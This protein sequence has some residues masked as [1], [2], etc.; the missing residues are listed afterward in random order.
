[1]TSRRGVEVIARLLRRAG[2]WHRPASLAHFE[3]AHGL[4]VLEGGGKLESLVEI[5]SRPKA[6][7]LR[8]PGARWRWFAPRTKAF[9]HRLVKRLLERESPL[10]GEGLELRRDV[11]IERDCSAH[12][13]HHSINHL[14]VKASYSTSV[15][16]RELVGLMMLVHHGD[17]VRVRL[18]AEVEGRHVHAGAVRP[19]QE[20]GPDRH[21]REEDRKKICALK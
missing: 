9:A 21:Q 3:L 8:I 10:A 18:R 15:I 17:A 19:S 12:E 4:F 16:R 7:G 14:A 13:L 6:H 2:G 1:M 20:S 5:D 11:W